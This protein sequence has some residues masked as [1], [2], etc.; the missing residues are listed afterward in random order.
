VC[1]IPAWCAGPGEVFAAADG[2]MSFQPATADEKNRTVDV[3]G[4]GDKRFRDR[5][6]T[7]EPFML[8][9]DM[10]GCRMERLNAGAPVFDCHMSGMDY[11]SVLAEQMGAKG[12]AGECGESVGRWP[13]GMAT[14]QFGVAGE[15]RIRTGCGP[16]SLPAAFGTSVWYMGL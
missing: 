10:A 15:T 14:L 3:S 12:A 13:E 5:P 4:T 9:L 6:A 8:R 11:R 7:G 1:S 2:E 16:A